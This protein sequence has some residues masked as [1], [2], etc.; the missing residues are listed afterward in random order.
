M[1]AARTS[2]KGPA[3]HARPEIG[4]N[5]FADAVQAIVGG[6]AYVNVHTTANGGGEIRGQ[7]AVF[8]QNPR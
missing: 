8:E 1:T 5:T 2:P 7:L 4:I 3:F 6:N